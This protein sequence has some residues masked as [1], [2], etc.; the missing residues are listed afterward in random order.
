MSAP[1]IALPHVH[2]YLAKS[3]CLLI[4]APQPS[5]PMP[6]AV[7]SFHALAPAIL[8]DRNPLFTFLGLAGPRFFYSSR[9]PLVISSGKHPVFPVWLKTSFFIFPQHPSESMSYL[10]LYLY[11]SHLFMCTFLHLDCQFFKASKLSAMPGV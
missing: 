5:P 7:F 6:H 11:L 2:L 4:C 10:L 1:V 3:N 9:L 8:S